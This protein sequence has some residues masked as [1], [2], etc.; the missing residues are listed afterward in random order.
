MEATKDDHLMEGPEEDVMSE[1]V[2]DEEVKYT[3]TARGIR[4]DDAKGILKTAQR[5]KLE[6]AK[7]LII[8]ADRRDWQ[9]LRRTRPMAEKFCT[10]NYTTTVL[11]EPWRGSFT[12]T[13][14][15]AKE[16]GWNDSQPID[17]QHNKLYDLTGSY[18]RWLLWNVMDTHWPYLTIIGFPCT[19]RSS[20][21][22]INSHID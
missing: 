15:G 18:G 10:D 17:M 1:A 22:A 2:E 7:E 20:L 21:T 9:E 3:R 19:V 14:I 5:K 4:Q 16:F 11:F 6:K 8:A 13:K 12:V